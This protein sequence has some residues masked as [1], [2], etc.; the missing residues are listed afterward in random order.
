MADLTQT[1]TNQLNVFGKSPTNRWNAFTWGTDVWAFDGKVVETDFD[2]IDVLT[3]TLS[4]SD[5]W[6]IVMSFFRTR[7]ETLNLNESSELIGSYVL[8]DGTYDYVFT[9][10]TNANSRTNPSYSEQSIDNA[11]YSTVSRPSTSW[12]ET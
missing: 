6:E 2:Q 5:T 1:I 7:T 12:T 3:D 4:M 10:G 11:T 8:S 9:G